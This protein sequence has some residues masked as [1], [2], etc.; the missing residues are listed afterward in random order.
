M[1]EN[2]NTS[3]V[4]SQTGTVENGKV[5]GIAYTLKN[6][7]GEIIDQASH[8]DPFF[9]IA[10][11]GHIVPGLENALSGLSIGTKKD[12]V[13]T[14]EEGYGEENPQLM[15]QVKRTQF[16]ADADLQVG[17]QFQA[18]SPDGHGMVFTVAGLEG[19]EVMID[20]NH[21]M[22]GE[23]LYFEIEVLSVREATAEELE[24]GHAHGP[25]GH[26]PH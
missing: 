22:A 18:H 19:D 20:G 2:N 4:A 8:E 17:M 13:V 6:A 24:H 11:E 23:T 21:P 15:M 25:E 7:E 1:S 3:S 26:H 10:G 9:Y 5:V 12:V 16:P 14:P